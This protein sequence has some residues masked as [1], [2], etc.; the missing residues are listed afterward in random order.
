MQEA[1]G[2]L[3]AVLTGLL[4]AQGEP[5]GTLPGP[6][7]PP[8]PAQAA[9]RVV[10]WKEGATLA[11]RIPVASPTREFMVTVSFP[12][13]SL[14]TAIT[15]WTD[16]ELTALPKRGLLFLRL[17]KKCE[18]QLNVVGA[19]GTH[20]LLELKGVELDGPEGHDTYVKIRKN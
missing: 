18:G 19:S 2:Y 11:I 20:Y 14:E 6:E 3:F 13:E 8:D 1:V 12:E 16:G 10:I 7:R 9:G 17:T 5:G 15:G 4:F